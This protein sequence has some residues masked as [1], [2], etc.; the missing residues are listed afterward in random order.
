MNADAMIFDNPQTACKVFGRKLR[1]NAPDGVL[2][3]GVRLAAQTKDDDPAELGR[4]VGDDVCEV[5]IE[6]NEGAVLAGAH[7]EHVFIR[8]AAQRLLDNGV[9]F[10]LRG[11]EH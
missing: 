7:I 1:Q 6:R 4:R 8:A 5:E 10:V 3:V 9:R 2:C 11:S